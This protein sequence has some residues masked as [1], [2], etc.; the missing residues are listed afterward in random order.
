MRSSIVAR[1]SVAQLFEVDCSTSAW[2]RV[3]DVWSHRR[4][5]YSTESSIDYSKSRKI[6]KK[7]LSD[8]RK[9]WYHEVQQADKRSAETAAAQLQEVQERLK[10]SKHGNRDITAKEKDE[11]LQK[12]EDERKAN[13]ALKSARRAENIHRESLRLSIL[14]S[15]REERKRDLLNQSKFWIGTEDELVQAVDKAVENVEP[16]YVT[17]KVRKRM[18]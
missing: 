8:L 17:R 6:Y 15:M 10:Q 12:R 3:V 1:R 9:E 11:I 7:S 18:E 16:L 13:M 4:D 5:F 14:Q 2:S